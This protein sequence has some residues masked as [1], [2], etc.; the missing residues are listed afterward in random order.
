MRQTAHKKATIR[1]LL[2]RTAKIVASH[3]GQIDF[4]LNLVIRKSSV[5]RPKDHA[6][7]RCA[8]SWLTKGI[9]NQVKIHEKDFQ[10]PHLTGPGLCLFP[11]HKH[12][13]S[14]H[15]VPLYLVIP[16]RHP[17]L[18]SHHLTTA[19]FTISPARPG[20]NNQER[21]R[22]PPAA[23]QAGI[24]SRTAWHSVLTIFQ[25]RIICALEAGQHLRH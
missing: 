22:Q 24:P 3:K 13:I 25:S 2:L 7:H 20:N 17:L 15:H 1:A 10:R 8:L 6:L 12:L 16:A 9:L 5:L 11:E 23:C 18:C 19:V 21:R 4:L 14:S